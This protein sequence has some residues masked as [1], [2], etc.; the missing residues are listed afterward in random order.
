[1]Q[2]QNSTYDTDAVQPINTT[3]NFVLTHYSENCH[4]AATPISAAFD[5]VQ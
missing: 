1:M 2:V 4:A 3:I 5:G